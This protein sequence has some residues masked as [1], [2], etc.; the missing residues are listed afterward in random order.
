M[1]I[2]STLSILIDRLSLANQWIGYLLVLGLCQLPVL[3]QSHPVPQPIAS[4]T[5]G[6]RVDFYDG[7]N[8]EQKVFSRR[9]QQLDYEWAHPVYAQ[10][11]KGL[12]FSARWMGKLRVPNDGLYRL[13]LKVDDGARLWLDGK[14]LIDKW[15]KLSGQSI[16]LKVK[17]AIYTTEVELKAGKYYELK[18]DYFNYLGPGVIKLYW[19]TPQT[20]TSSFFGLVTSRER[21]MIPEKYLYTA[22]EIPVA[23][24]VK[25]QASAH[26]A[27]KA[28]SKPTTMVA[29]KTGQA[30]LPAKKVVRPPVIQAQGNAK[31][32]K[33][34]LKET[35][36][37][38]EV[39]KAFVLN[40][41]FFEQSK[42]VLQV[43]SYP[44]LDQ[45][46]HTLQK[47]P[48][49]HITIAGHTDQ[50]G[51]AKL[52]QIL[53]EQRAQVVANYLTRKGIAGSRITVRGYGGMQPLATNNSEANRAK[54]RRVE[55]TI[56][57]VEK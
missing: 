48:A 9:D 40:Q 26:A 36:E 3:A 55:F 7:I 22:P 12:D 18:I 42:Y 52:N 19:E 16:T 31:E 51:E 2:A 10:G 38:L 23:T 5:H 47:Y 14:L 49:W 53:S 28:A 11:L 24:P 13:V 41:V 54:N 8:F 27:P 34:S 44:Q 33:P 45:L 35:F 4:Q 39:G 57:V 46:A 20:E 6:L 37:Q 50:V 43:E 56:Q 25:T 30:T 15:Y 29:N 21:E 17:P 1:N 32:T